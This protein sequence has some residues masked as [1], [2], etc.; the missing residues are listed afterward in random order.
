MIRW[1]IVGLLVLAACGGATEVSSSTSTT[2][3]PAADLD[4]T[5]AVGI[6]RTAADTFD[7][8][9]ITGGGRS[10][11]VPLDNPQ[12]RPASEATWLDDGDIVMGIVHETGET[13]AYP[14]NQMAYHHIANTTVAGEPFLVTY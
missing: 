4:V 10:S 8:A 9:G 13:Q 1:T 2:T 12:M 6:T 14:V 7:D 5:P 3:F 11:F